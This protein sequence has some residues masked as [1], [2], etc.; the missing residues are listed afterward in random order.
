[1]SSAGRVPVSK[2]VVRGFESS[3]PCQKIQVERLG[4]FHLCRKAQHHLRA[5]HATS[6]ERQLNIVAA[7]RHK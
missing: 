7:P 5:T 3:C 6:F 2:T 4:F 1:Y